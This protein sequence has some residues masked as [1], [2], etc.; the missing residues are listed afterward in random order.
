MTSEWKTEKLGDICDVKIG[1]TPPRSQEEWFS[2]KNGLSWASIKDMGN[3]GKY[4]ESTKEYLTHKAVKQFKIPIVK[5]GTIL[6]SFKLTVGRLSIA[7]CD[8]CTNEAIAQLS[9]P[10]INRDYLYYYLKNFNYDSNSYK[11]NNFKKP[12]CSISATF[13]AK[14]N[15]LYS[16][17]IR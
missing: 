3:N 1:K 9:N 13:K 10:K 15:S 2:L 6:L 8:M 4:L 17:N 16:F 5:K 7:N 14:E 12:S 11:L